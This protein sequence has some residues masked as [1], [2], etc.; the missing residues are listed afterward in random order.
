MNKEATIKLLINY[1]L[2]TCHVW[3]ATAT[4]ELERV[5]H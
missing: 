5:A 4:Q 1:N 3:L 2:L